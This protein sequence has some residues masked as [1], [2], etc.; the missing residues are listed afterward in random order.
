M[1]A[2]S[3]YHFLALVTLLT[4]LLEQR[5]AIETVVF[6]LGWTRELLLEC[7]PFLPVL[8]HMDYFL[9][10]IEAVLECERYKYSAE[11]LLIVGSCLELLVGFY[12]NFPK[13]ELAKRLIEICCNQLNA[14][15]AEVAAVFS[16]LLP[17]LPLEQ[18]LG[19]ISNDG[20]SL[21]RTR[22]ALLRSH[23]TRSTHSFLSARNFKILMNYLLRGEENP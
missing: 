18:T 5:L 20:D 15:N 1:T 8:L 12:N 6:S 7:Q 13:P 9:P 19:L 3:N 10:L 17:C 14:T 2:E 11:V 4:R 16:G 22:V 21:S 23:V